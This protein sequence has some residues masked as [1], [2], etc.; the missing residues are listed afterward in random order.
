MKQPRSF[1]GR[2][3]RRERSRPP[4][5][6]QSAAAEPAQEPTVPTVPSALP[7]ARPSPS[8]DWA[9]IVVDQPGPAFEANAPTVAEYCPDTVLTG[10][11]R[12]ASPS[13]WRPSGAICTA[14]AARPDR[15]ASLRESTRG[16]G[17]SRSPWPTEFKRHAVAHRSVD[18][19]QHAR[20]PPAPNAGERPPRRS[21]LCGRSSRIQ[22]HQASRLPATAGKPGPKGCRRRPLAT[23]L[24]AGF[25]R[26]DPEHGAIATLVQIGDSGAW[27]LRSGRYFSLFDPKNNPDAELISSAVSPLPRIPAETSTVQYRLAPEDVLLVGTDGFGYLLGD[28]DGLVGLLFAEHLSTPPPACGLAPPARLLTRY[29]GRRSHTGGHLAAGAEKAGP[30]PSCHTGGS[31][32]A[33]SSQVRATG[34]RRPMGRRP[35]AGWSILGCM[36]SSWSSR[37]EALLGRR[38]ELVERADV[39]ALIGSQV[40]TVCGLD[41]P[42]VA[43]FRAVNGDIIAAMLDSKTV[44][45][46]RRP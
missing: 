13:A 45:A 39:R 23:T 17:L 34:G 5:Q 16:P 28:G 43:R 21:F 12:G 18:R 46:G 37:L 42:G 14:T 35:P 20:R 36:V 11:P 6:E 1:I 44:A 22:D 25:V 27:I 40:A 9:P 33:A 26:F 3:R 32:G 19:L 15:T 30:G 10:G 7:A 2:L 31:L 38:L 29:V 41:E 24:T 4:A 8:P